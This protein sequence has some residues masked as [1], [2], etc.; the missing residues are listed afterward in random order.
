MRVAQWYK[1]FV[2]FIGIMFSLNLTNFLMLSRVIIAF[3]LFCILS[4]SVYLINDIHDIDKDRMHPFKRKRPIPSGRMSLNFAKGL[5]TFFI[6]VSLTSA[7]MLSNLLFV[8]CVVYLVQNILYTFWLKSIVIVDVA[9]ISAGFVW[10]AIAGVVV[11]S[12]R[13]SPWL[14]ICSFLLAL[15]LALNKRKTEIGLLQNVNEHRT[16]LKAYSKQLLDTLLNI[17]TASLLMFYMI[18]TFESGY[19]YMIITIPFAFIG[20]FRYVQL[21]AESE[22]GNDDATFIFRDKL[23]QVNLLLW[24]LTSAAALYK[25]PDLIVK[26][27]IA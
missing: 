3:G 20:I 5:A 2:I 1:N 22:N 4:S 12:V 24:A 16:T 15:F 17:T 26:L 9:V 7:F 6:I 23:T 8:V 19:I 21:V 18:Y 13:I 11:I 10:R 14:I 27:L 25:I